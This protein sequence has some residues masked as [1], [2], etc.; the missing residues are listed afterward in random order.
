MVQQ[1]R[2]MIDTE[3]C[4]LSMMD[5]IIRTQSTPF[6]L[7]CYIFYNL[8]KHLKSILIFVFTFTV[9]LCVFKKKNK[10]KKYFTTLLFFWANSVM[11][12]YALKNNFMLKNWIRSNMIS[13]PQ[14]GRVDHQSI[15]ITRFFF[16]IFCFLLRK[17]QSI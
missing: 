13:P 11:K 2:Y 8:K 16:Q 4:S 6:L 17:Q 14:R 15:P 10:I 7:Y 12:R 1:E 9:V 5:S 3:E